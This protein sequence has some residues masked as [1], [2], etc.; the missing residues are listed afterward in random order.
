MWVVVH[1]LCGHCSLVQLRDWR[2]SPWQSL[3]PVPGEGWVH[4]LLLHIEQ[5][6]PHADHLLHSLQPPST[7]KT[8]SIKTWASTNTHTHTAA[9]NSNRFTSNTCIL[10]HRE[11]NYWSETML[12]SFNK[13]SYN[14]FL[15]TAW[16]V[17]TWH[18]EVQMQRWCKSS[19][20]FACEMRT[21]GTILCCHP[22]QIH[23][24]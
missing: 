12:N 13:T 21:T 4:S 10:V 16:S 8:H 7:A 18:S 2:S 14:F 15:Q 6:A 5:S 20:V 11:K 19:G 23:S 24:L 9:K 1:S 3:P 17:K 22:V